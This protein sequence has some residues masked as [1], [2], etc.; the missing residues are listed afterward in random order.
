MIPLHRAL[1]KEILDVADLASVYADC[2]GNPEFLPAVI[3]ELRSEDPVT[4]PVHPGSC[5]AIPQIGLGS[6]IKSSPP[7]LKPSQTRLPGQ[8]GCICAS[9]SL[10]SFAPPQGRSRSWNFF[11]VVPPTRGP[12]FGMGLDGLAP[13]EAGFPGSS[14]RNRSSV[15]ASSIR[16]R[17]IGPSENASNQR[18]EPDA[19]AKAEPNATANGAKPPRLS[20]SGQQIYVFFTENGVLA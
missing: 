6:R 16:S 10:E 11:P 5:F 12:S 19:P 18:A 2:A 7:P 9:C 13:V 1:A 15:A 17:E 20:R 4:S 3:T 14:S 8:D